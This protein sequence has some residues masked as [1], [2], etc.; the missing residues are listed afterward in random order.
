MDPPPPA[1]DARAWLG[2]LAAGAAPSEAEVLDL[3][4]AFGIPTAAH[5]L[6]GNAA[7]AD[8]AA[9]RVGFPVVLKT[10]MPGI[11]HKSERGGVVLDLRDAVAVREAYGS[12]ATALGPRVMLA[13]MLPA[14]PELALGAV[15]DPQFGPV[16]MLGA[17]GTLVE[18]L[19]DRVAALPPFGPATA[20][21]LLDRLRM[22]RMLDGFRGGP[23]TDLAVLADLVA[24]FSVLVHELRAVVREIDVNPVICGP[25][26]AAVDGLLV[27]G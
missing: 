16:V 23:A 17:G 4:G 27:V 5:A 26:P 13:R 3:L 7:D 14:G 2:R 6:A 10:A 19:D 22:R 8:A 11:A 21:R 12:M 20:R 25:F 1:P 18:L 15:R 24:R 9:S